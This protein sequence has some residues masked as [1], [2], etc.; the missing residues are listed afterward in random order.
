MNFLKFNILFMLSLFV[1][2][3]I[4]SSVSPSSAAESS[5]GEVGS[6]KEINVDNMK[7]NVMD[8][9]GAVNASTAEIVTIA[10]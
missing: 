5:T 1:I 10:P 8:A 6:T 9:E 3:F 2:S 7:F 4:L